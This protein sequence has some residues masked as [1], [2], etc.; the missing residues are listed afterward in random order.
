MPV[1]SLRNACFRIS[2][3]VLLDNVTLQI[4][5]G[6]RIGLLGRNGAGK[7]TLMR[8][9]GG[10]I[11]P[12]EGIFQM[13]NFIRTSRL[14]QEVPEGPDR[15]VIDI[16]QNGLIQTQNQVTTP[17]KRR[18]GQWKTE[19]DIQN[20]LTR[21]GLD[22]K[23]TFS[24]LSSGMKRRVLLAQTLFQKPDLLLLDEPTN[25][26]DIIAIA[27]LERFLLEYRGTLVF[28]THD[29]VFLQ[30]LATR[31]IEIDRARLFDWTCDYHTFLNRKQ[32]VLQE[33]E[34]HLQEFDKK[35]SQEEQWIRQGIKA[36]RTRNEGRVRALEQMR[37]ERRTR[38]ER[39]GQ[40]AFQSS[41]APRSG[42]LVMESKE[43]SFAY[44]EV[45]VIKDLSLRILRGDKIGIIGPNGAGKSTLLKLL[46]RDIEPDNGEIRHGTD[47]QVVYYD[48]QREVL[49]EDK[50]V[51]EIVGEGQ[52]LLM[53]NG[54]QR[55]LFSYLRDFLF[56]P[57][58]AKQ[59]ATSL[60]GGERNRLFLARL[61]KQP[62]NLLVLDEP[63][64][65]LDAETLELLEEY[66]VQYTGTLLL[67]SHDRAFLNN[68]VTSTLVFEEDGIIKE[69][70]GSYDDYRR[71]VR[72]RVEPESPDT[73]LRSV[74]SP[75]RPRNRE[76]HKLSYHEQREL[77]RIPEVISEMEENLEKLH[78]QV[79]SPSFLKGERAIIL[80][81]NQAIDELENNLKKQYARWEQLETEQSE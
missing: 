11:V 55:H 26:L 20:E 9:M 2:D 78:E 66:V 33:E 23:A 40:A 39:P 35:L 77:E 5:A 57:E 28:V 44:D 7:S 18:D 48:Q 80:A 45:P 81:A 8:I 63:T 47:L 50:T 76:Q 6:E 56:S 51:A 54:R 72:N 31:I 58:Q 10:E 71:Q 42:Q 67:V 36:R 52:E 60:S 53:I 73:V 30:T 27:E 34:K 17:D 75:K 37:L 21:F 1:L 68:I 19:R 65:D 29:R 3:R 13:E 74:K 43:A 4:H 16:I 12:D 24:S 64:N 49:N 15:P 41:T 22:G 59:K 38:R 25:H 69:Y 70:I 32:L 61:L 79:S 62:S 14:I 46:L